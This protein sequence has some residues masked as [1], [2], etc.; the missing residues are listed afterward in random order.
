[1]SFVKT[2]TS[3]SCYVRVSLPYAWNLFGDKIE[4]CAFSA[5][6]SVAAFFIVLRGGNFM[7]LHFCRK[8]SPD[9]R[10]IFLNFASLFGNINWA[11]QMWIGSYRIV[12]YTPYDDNSW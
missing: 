11:K 9:Y 1:M 10:I 2:Q 6:T 4:V 7:A 8:T 12:E 5:A 3:A